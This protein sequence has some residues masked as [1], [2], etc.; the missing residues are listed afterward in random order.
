LFQIFNDQALEEFN[1]K[2]NLSF[3]KEKIQNT[4]ELE[5]VKLIDTKRY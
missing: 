2:V 5:G 4:I 3:F 1:Q